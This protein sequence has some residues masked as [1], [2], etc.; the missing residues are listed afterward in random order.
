MAI[1][2][3][4]E[5]RKM[6]KGKRFAA[7]ILSALVAASCIGSVSASAFSKVEKR[8]YRGLVKTQKY[9]SK[10][11]CAIMGWMKWSSNVNYKTKGGV[12]C[13]TYGRAKQMKQQAK[14]ERTSWKSE[15]FQRRFIKKELSQAGANKKLKKTSSLSKKVSIVNDAI[16]RAPSR[17]Q[18]KATDYAAHYYN[19]RKALK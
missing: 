19:H 4:C 17:S 18:G 7:I 16:V 5:E 2:S 1:S 13:W 3:S 14:K 6:K 8:T 15:K 12:L 10:D 9:S 11:A